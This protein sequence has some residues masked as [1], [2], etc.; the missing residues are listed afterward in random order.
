MPALTSRLRRADQFAATLTYIDDEIQAQH[1]FK[2]QDMYV[3]KLWHWLIQNLFLSSNEGLQ[4]GI[5][6][7]ARLL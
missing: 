7:W 2:D 4:I 6:I 3:S 1:G 5:K